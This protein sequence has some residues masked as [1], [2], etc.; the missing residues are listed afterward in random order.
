MV[1]VRETVVLVVLR[2][3]SGALV[4]RVLGFGVAIFGAVGAGRAACARRGVN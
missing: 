2:A 4:L 3:F 1:G